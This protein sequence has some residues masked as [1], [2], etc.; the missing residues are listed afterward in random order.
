MIINP[1]D[2]NL[3]KVKRFFAFGCSFTRDRWP[4]WADILK[5][6]MPDAEY[7]NAGRSGAG[8]MM[9]AC[10]IVEADYRFNFNSD[11]L[12]VVMWTTHC[13]EDRWMNGSWLHPGNIFT[14]GEYSEKFVKKFCDPAGYLVKDFALMSMAYNFLENI[15]ANAVSMLSVPFDFQQD[16]NIDFYKNISS[17]YKSFLDKQLPTMYEIEFNRTWDF[18]HTYKYID[19]SLFRDYHP[20]PKRYFNYLKKLNFNLTDIS[21]RYA[22]AS[23]DK[24]LSAKTVDDLDKMFGHM[25]DGHLNKLL[26]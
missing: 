7:Y 14:Q 20:N 18:G 2:I 6:E 11:D 17:V 15:K 5:T 22:N 1:K 9:I 21:K 13:R 12:I 8:N 3:L 10:R 16:E 26:F 24:L 23:A 25:Y 4:T 19:G